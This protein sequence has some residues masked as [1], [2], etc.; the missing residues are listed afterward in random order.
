ERVGA[1]IKS[2]R[3]AREEDPQ[4]ITILILQGVSI[5]QRARHDLEINRDAV[6]YWFTIED[7]LENEGKR[8]E[9]FKL[10]GI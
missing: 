6:T 1:A 2:L 9:I 4:S 5:M 7:V 10:L 8:E 3:R